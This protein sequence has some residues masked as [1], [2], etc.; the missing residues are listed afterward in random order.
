M[1][2][3]LLSSIIITL[4]M[5]VVNS[6]NLSFQRNKLRTGDKLIKQQLEYIDPGLDGEG[7][8]WNFS[9]ISIN[10][11]A[12][13]LLYVNVNKKDTTKFLGLEHDT[14][15]RYTQDQDTLFLTGFDNRNTFIRF[16]KPEAQLAFP[17]K[18]GDSIV[19]EF[20]GEGLYCNKIKLI[21]NGVTVTCVDATG[22]LI[23]PELDTLKNALR[24]KR[25]RTYK[26]IGLDST[27][28]NLTTYSW[29]VPGYRYP[30]FETIK[31][32]TIK[33]DSI[34]Q[35][36]TTSFYYSIENTKK[37]TTDL[38]N[39]KLQK[40]TNNVEPIFT[41]AKVSPN[42]VTEY[43]Y[44]NYKLT[45]QAKIWFSVHNNAGIPIYRSSPE[46]IE[47]GY[48]VKNIY[49]GSVISGTYTL[50]AHVD[51]KIIKMNIIKK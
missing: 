38:A 20:K 21:A 26:E 9:R 4:T 8:V 36:F 51:D 47:E 17:F 16:N 24:V 32:K 28:L 33:Q 37:L 13:R 12:Y 15:Y 25:I 18:Y 14:R 40:A 23:T 45:Q 3:K 31:S 2:F 11:E 42:P 27:V 46:D 50:Y 22:V 48:H 30:I 39:D 35:N 41:E 49:L 44:L 1:K 43:L 29:Y 5:T 34:V 19:S 10:N 7:L 6:Q